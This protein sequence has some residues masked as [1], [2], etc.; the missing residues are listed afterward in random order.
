MSSLWTPPAEGGGGGAGGLGAEAFRVKGQAGV[1]TDRWFATP[2][3]LGSVS[4]AAPTVDRLYLEPF[5]SGS[6]GTLDRIGIHHT[7]LA[8]AGG[9]VR[10]G[11]YETTSATD[12]TPG[13]LRLDA[14]ALA[15]DASSGIKAA[16]INHELEADKLYW[17]AA[18][19]GVA[20]PGSV[21]TFGGN[22]N[23]VMWN[24][25]GHDNQLGFTNFDHLYK[26]FPYAALP[27]PVGAGLTRGSGNHP[28]IAVRFSA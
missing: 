5:L 6:G 3:S 11:I 24:I 27:N 9:V 23:L 15:T 10:V 17:L 20:V 14:G 19:F 18:V 21:R 7:S 26:A 1:F 28:V 2:E 22:T 13:A 16:T 8:A 25:I 12:P 4:T